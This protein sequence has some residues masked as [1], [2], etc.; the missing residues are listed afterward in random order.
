MKTKKSKLIKFIPCFI[1]FLLFVAVVPF[2][3]GGTYGDHLG[4]YGEDDGIHGGNRLAMPGIYPEMDPRIT[5][6]ATEV[7][8]YWRPAGI[9]FGTSTKVLDQPGGT[10]DVFSLGDGGWITVGFDQA[11]YNG[12]GV[13]FAVWE[14]GFISTQAGDAGWLF[15]ELMF[16]EVSSNGTNFVRFPSVCRNPASIDGFGCIDPTYYHNVAGKHPNGNDGGDEGTPF[17]LD[18]LLADPLV[19]QGLLDLN[20][21]LYVKLIDV[22]G[23]G[24]TYDFGGNPMYDPYPTPFSTG[25]ADLDAIGVLNAVPVPGAV[26]LLG[27]GLLGLIGIRRKKA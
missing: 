12:S 10:M 13:D 21:I 19:S 18:D 7:E 14:N 6:W 27:S 15:A 20:N 26:W 9:T 11:I 5:G 23:D 16:V 1:F 4:P 25:G 17:D 2:A 3:F 8:D 22:I 24:L